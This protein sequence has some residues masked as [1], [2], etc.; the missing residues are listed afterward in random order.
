[1]TFSR[2]SLDQWRALQA[3][4]DQGGFTQAA[5][6][7][8]R[9]QSAISYAVQR[10]QQQL[11]VEVLQIQGRRA[12]LTE[13][14]EALLHR[15]RQLLHDADSLEDLARELDA[16]WEAEVHLAVEGVFPTDILLQAL[17]RFAQHNHA[18]RVQ[19]L[20]V[21]LS[22]AEDALRSAQ[23]DLVIAAMQFSD[24][25]ADPLIDIEFIAVAHPHH[26]LHLLG[27]SLQHADLKRETQIVIRD[28]GQQNTLNAGWLGADQR[29]TVSSVDR[30]I[31]LT[32]RGLGYA[33]L[34]HSHI[35]TALRDGKLQPLPLVRGQRHR[36]QLY[37]HYAQPEHVGPATRL[38]AQC[39]QDATK[40]S[41]SPQ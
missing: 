10:L 26:P 7:L 34:P 27:R 17:N 24:K 12:V 41:G 9:S 21:M 28:S 14:G 2:V 39:L 11:G 1:M 32:Q 13:A 38:L 33:W 40:E 15:A 20:D 23:T 8:Y 35:A 36:A 16:G 25:L 18:T 3:V 19:L 30:A 5:A 37:L 4:V 29:W 31:S 6:H 22:G